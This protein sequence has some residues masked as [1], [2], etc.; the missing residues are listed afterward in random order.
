MVGRLITPFKMGTGGKLGNGQQI[1]SWISRTDWVRAVI[2]IIEQNLTHTLPTQQIYNLTNPTPISNAA[3]TDAM[4]TWLHRPT[5][6]TLPAFVVKT[7]FGEMSTL[8][9]D[10]QRVVPTALLDKGFE[11]NDLTVLDALKS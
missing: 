11:F 2:F 3:F 6:M 7:M 9:L 10:G 5:L 1:M 8:L 4:G